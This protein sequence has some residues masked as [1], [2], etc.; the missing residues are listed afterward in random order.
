MLR[1]FFEYLLTP[2][3]PAV[4]ALGYLRESI[5]I[6]SRHRRC[7]E[8]WREHLENSRRQILS[9]AETLKPGSHIVIMGS[10]A[11]HDVPVEGLRERGLRLSLVD[12]VHLPAVRKRYGRDDHIHFVTVDVTGK[13]ANIFAPKSAGNGSPPALDL[14]APPDLVVSLNILSQLALLPLKYLEKMGEKVPPDFAEEIMLAHLDWLAGFGCPV[15]LVSDFERLYAEKDDV[16][17]HEE[18]LPDKVARKLGRPEQDWV[19]RI[20]P[21]GELDR[22]IEVRHRVGFWRPDAGR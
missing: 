21:A 14:A 16:L 8:A 10:G 11:L 9:A 22:K 5:S 12:I 3:E 17:E 4:K 19:W 15:A 18:A 13:A 1:E 2:A 6:E 7:R 20:A